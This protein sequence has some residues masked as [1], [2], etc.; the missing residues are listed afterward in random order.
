MTTD[1]TERPPLDKAR[2]TSEHPELMPDLTVEVVDVLESS[3]AVAA[4]RAQEG[5]PDGLVI[6]ADH[7]SAGRGRLDRTWETPPGTAVTFSVLLR[8]DAPTRSWPWLPLLT[9]YA[10]DKALKS[11][12]LEAGVKWP[13]DVLVGEK[14]VAGILVER[15]ETPT[16]PAAIVGVGI[17]VG[18]R[19]DELPVPTATSLEIELGRPVDRTDVLVEVLNAIREAVD[20][21]ELGGDLNGMRLRDSYAAACVTVGRD[22]RV[23]L[24]DGS[25]LE[26]RAVEIDPTGQ[27]V[28]EHDGVRTPVAAGDVVHVRTA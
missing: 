10:V 13:N 28:V 4:E 12:G 3:N 27:L 26:G 24:P 15:L 14:K 1:S 23:D 22:V 6:V 5:A 20:A 8:P 17:N 9:G 11:H 7:Q 18:L 2:L 25:V 21:W 16:G 19:A